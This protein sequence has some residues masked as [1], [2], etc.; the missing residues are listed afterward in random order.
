MSNPVNFISLERQAEI[1]DLIEKIKI[2]TGLSYP[3]DSLIDIIKYTI[4]QVSIK[5]DSFGDK[6]G[7]M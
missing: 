2:Q 6:K 3:E 1:V 5:E 7:K 4:P